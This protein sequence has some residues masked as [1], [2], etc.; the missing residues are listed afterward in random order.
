MHKTVC[1]R[2]HDTH[3]RTQTNTHTHVCVYVFVNRDF[4]EH[5]FNMSTFYCFITRH[6]PSVL[7]KRDFL[8]F[9]PRS[10]RTVDCIFVVS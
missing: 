8:A 9:Q 4:H 1:E 7:T 3:T 2:A 5:I 6:E 10:G